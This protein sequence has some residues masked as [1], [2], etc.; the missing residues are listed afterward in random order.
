MDAVRVV[1]EERQSELDELQ[2]HG[3]SRC[4]LATS[5]LASTTSP[6]C[7]TR[8]RQK[9][10]EFVAFPVPAGPKGRGYMPVL[11]GLAVMNG[12]PDM[13]RAM[14]LIDYLTLPKTQID[15]GPRSRLSAGGGGEVAAG[16]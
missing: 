2:F 11:V 14:A 12:A 7:S 8:L 10:S 15:V 6:A 3:G 5:G 16:P 9:P 13:A 1:M 4:F